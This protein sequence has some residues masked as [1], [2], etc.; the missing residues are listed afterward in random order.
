MIRKNKGK[1]RVMAK[2]DLKVILGLSSLLIF[3]EIIFLILEELLENSQ[4]ED[5]IRIIGVKKIIQF[6]FRLMIEEGSKIENI[7]II[8]FRSVYGKLSWIFLRKFW[9]K[10]NLR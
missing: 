9:K 7:L 2:C 3:F 10:M 8:I 5:G 6:K 1:N 4:N